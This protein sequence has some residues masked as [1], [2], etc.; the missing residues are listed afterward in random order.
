MV[1]SYI[2]GFKSFKVKKKKKK[3]TFKRQNTSDGRI[4]EQR[5]KTCSMVHPYLRQR[6]ETARLNHPTPIIMVSYV[7]NEQAKF[8][9]KNW[10]TFLN[11]KS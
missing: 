10:F 6:A 1:G 7:M 9:K 3:N 8:Q 5:Q 4:V 2:L 11:L